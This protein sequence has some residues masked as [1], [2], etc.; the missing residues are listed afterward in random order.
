[1][2]GEIAL[3][4]LAGIHFFA[5]RMRV[6][7]WVWHGK[8]LSFASGVSFAYVF[9]DLL[10]TLE[11]GQPILKQALGNFLPYL[12]KHVY[13]IAF[14]GVLFFYGVHSHRRSSRESWLLL[15]GYWIFNFL[16]GTSLVDSSN[17]EIQPLILYTIAVG[18]H[19][20]VRDHVERIADHRNSQIALVFA[21]FA[22]YAFGYF[23]KVP[24]SIVMLIIAFIGGGIILN[25]LH[26]ELPQKK[27]G[28]YLYFF[29]GSVLYGGLLLLQGSL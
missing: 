8:F 21:L 11:H 2:S 1:V 27:K 28:N 12:D 24:D 23:A 15:S 19:Y 10:P 29:L 7:G 13:L 16:V 9:I 18:M 20:F 14:L 22:G 3:L 26:Y 4:V 5:N 6:L 17:P 25:V